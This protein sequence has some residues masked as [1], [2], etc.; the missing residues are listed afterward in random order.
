MERGRIAT[1][2]AIGL[3]CSACGGGGGG[4]SPAAYA[5][6]YVGEFIDA[7]GSVGQF[8]LA[9]TASNPASCTGQYTYPSGTISFT[10]QIGG[11]GQ[12]TV[13]IRNANVTDYATMQLGPS[14]QPTAR[15]SFRPQL[16]IELPNGGSG[17]TGTTG[18]TGTTGTTSIFPVAQVVLITNTT[19]FF[20]GANPFSGNYAG[21]IKDTTLNT[22]GLLALSIDAS[23]KVSGSGSVSN[24]GTQT[25]ISVSG[26]LS[27]GGT[28]N[29][30]EQ[31]GNES[32]AG[33]VALSKGTISGALKLSNGDSAEI[34]LTQVKPLNIISLPPSGRTK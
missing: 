10:G 24:S 6:S 22:T 21:T 9:V 7:N 28:L 3:G 20:G 19:G 31:T 14:V 17:T 33:T 12:G 34:S 27:A 2:L 29:Y 4:T 11:G 26:T 8:S 5:G 25:L 23:G 16:I 13:N 32:A 15:L 18:G 30:V 1:L